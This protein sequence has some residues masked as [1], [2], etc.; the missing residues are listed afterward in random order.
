MI[1]TD[2]PFLRPHN[3]PENA[4]LFPDTLAALRNTDVETSQPYCHLY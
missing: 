3:A 4:Q 1:E 2:G